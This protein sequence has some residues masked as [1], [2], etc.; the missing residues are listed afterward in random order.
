[1]V[2]AVPATP[3]RFSVL[4]VM[5]SATTYAEVTELVINAARTRCSLVLAATSVHG[6]TVAARDPSFLEIL[7]SL[8]VITPDGQP[9]RW[10]LNVLH[11]ARLSERVYGPT[12]MGYVC[13]AA[14][15]AGL[16][17]YFY[18]STPDV[19][20]CL[21]VRL[22]EQFPGLRIAGSH[23]PPFRELTDEEQTADAEQIVQSGADIVFVGLG[24]PRQERWAARQRLLVHAPILCVGAAFD[25]HA[26]T[27][28]QAPPWM[29]QR[30]LEWL[31]RL[32][33]EPR[34]LWRRYAQ[35]IPLFVMLLSRQYLEQRI[36]TRMAQ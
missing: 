28:R 27:L 7:N 23:S 35:A 19:L 13:A 4:G 14:E 2:A 5:A 9:V 17:V 15:T 29:Q 18:G 8:D 31:F 30:G 3:R 34:R 33:M 22:G 26:G 36:R 24:C 10:A 25:F 20:D 32:G 6:V 12:L 1:V 11:G 16:S 21:S